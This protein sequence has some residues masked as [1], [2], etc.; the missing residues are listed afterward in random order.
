[1]QRLKL[2]CNTLILFNIIYLAWMHNQALASGLE[3]AEQ[4]TSQAYDDYYR[5][6]RMNPGLTPK[7]RA[8]IADQKVQPA[9]VSRHR[10]VESEMRESLSAFGLKPGRVSARDEKFTG[11]GAE[12]APKV[13]GQKDSG[14]ADP[15]GAPVSMGALRTVHPSSESAENEAPVVRGEG[16]GVED[17]LYFGKAKRAPAVESGSFIKK[18]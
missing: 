4:A 10:A 1:M 17:T 2:S 15:A 13:L 8:Q 7:Q 18:K 16:T 9:E 3:S 11:E 14:S 6:V 12:S 5:A